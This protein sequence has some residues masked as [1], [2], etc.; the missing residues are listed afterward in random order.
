[1]ARAHPHAA[2]AFE[3]HITTASDDAKVVDGH[4]RNGDPDLVLHFAVARAAGRLLGPGTRPAEVFAY[5]ADDLIVAQL[6]TEL[7][8]GAEHAP[9]EYAVLNACRAWKFAVDRTLVS[10]IDGGLWA[11]CRTEESDRNLIAAAIDGQRSGLSAD[12]DRGAV[13][14]FVQLSLSRLT[15]PS[16]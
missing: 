3:L 4:Q 15:R 14:R 9:G 12:L 16:T 10:K 11:L 5:V 6:A 1:M 8:W 7:R 13:R 2:P